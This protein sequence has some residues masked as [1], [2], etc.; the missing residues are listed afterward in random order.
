MCESLLNVKIQAVKAYGAVEVEIHSLLASA[1]GHEWLTSR[2]DSF[3]PENNPGTRLVGGWVDP[4]E[5]LDAIRRDKSL[6]HA[7]ILKYTEYLL[8][9]SYY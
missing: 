1:L 5:G 8:I 3:N 9:Y 7:G 2:P 6:G 4:R